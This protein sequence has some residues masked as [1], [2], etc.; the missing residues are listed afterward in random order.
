MT[1]HQA[2]TAPQREYRAPFL[3]ADVF[4]RAA[5]GGVFHTARIT[6]TYHQLGGGAH[7]TRVDLVVWTSY[8]QAFVQGAEY[9]PEGSRP[10]SWCWP[11]DAPNQE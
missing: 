2:I 6:Q 1:D 7:P 8:S 4:Y 9:H 11:E 3:G 10:G 5:R